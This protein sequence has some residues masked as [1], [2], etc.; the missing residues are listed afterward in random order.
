M[1]NKLCNA[2]ALTRQGAK[3]LITGSVYSA[4]QNIALM[5][6]VAITVL[7]LREA[8]P[9]LSDSGAAVPSLPKY[10]V[11]IVAALAIIFF[12]AWKQYHFVYNTTYLESAN[13]RVALAEKL[14][15]LPLSFFGQRDLSDLT[16]IIMGDCTALEH[17]FSHIIPQLCGACM[18][19]LLVGIGLFVLDWRMA[20]AL[21]WVVPVSIGITVG[22]KFIQDKFGKRNTAAKLHVADGIQECLETIRE[23][24]ASN[25]SEEYLS[26]LDDKLAC[27]EKS[28]IRTE[29]V[30]G[31][32]VTA[33]QMLLRLGIVSV[34][35]TGG[36]LLT[37]GGID[38]LTYVVFLM[39]CSRVYD[40]LYIVLMHIAAVFSAKLQIG[41]MKE[42]ENQPEQGGTQNYA[43]D[44]YDIVF[45]H[46]K[47]AYNSGET[48]LADV[49]FTAKQGEITALVGPSGGGK[50]TAAKLAA[51]FWDI[52]RGKITIGG[53]DV[54]AVQPETLLQSYSIVF[55]DVVLFRDTIMENIRLGKRDATDE[56]VIAA[57]K[58]ANCDSF[59]AKLPEG[60]HTLIGENGS[61]LSGGERQRI[62]IARAL[63]KNAPVILLDEATAS[64]DVENET[65]IQAA[66]SRLVKDKTVLII[67][68]RMRTVAGADNVV[69]LENGLVAQQGAPEKLMSAGGLY[70]HMVGLQRES[71]D[72]TI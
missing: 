5:L 1:L 15:K 55:Q 21:L 57:A 26:D 58:A 38:L 17:S 2:L 67:A 13:R 44:R 30:T 40:P 3:D 25:R 37:S 66:I 7:F 9:L 63:L 12:F 8:L 28:A 31:V 51:R 49:S 16:T 61:T 27:A 50:S 29:L 69:V 62:S 41:R 14:R 60:Y 68:H 56:E 46:V 52:D 34:I 72:W 36:L 33:A 47:F 22:T 19:V 24:K 20:L 35:V 71:A 39:A 10:I 6:P 54:A 23:I 18:S 64:L 70:S 45:D 11:M 59:A 42:I 4:L 48:V 65:E 53:V 43:P 32:C